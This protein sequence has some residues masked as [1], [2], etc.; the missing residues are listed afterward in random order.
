MYKYQVSCRLQ[1]CL[2]LVGGFVK[3]MHAKHASSS[4]CYA[5]LEQAAL[6]P[7]GFPGETS[8]G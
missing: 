4:T 7:A 5:V 1:C 2:S 3:Q 6:Y 8:V